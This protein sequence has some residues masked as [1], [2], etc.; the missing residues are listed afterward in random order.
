MDFMSF[1]WSVLLMLNI[2]AYFESKPMVG[3]YIDKQIPFQSYAVVI[4][5]HKLP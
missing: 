4:D 1:P 2:D 3:I 5:L